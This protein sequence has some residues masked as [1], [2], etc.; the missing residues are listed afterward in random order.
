MTEE[1]LPVV[2]LWHMHQPQ[3]RDALTGEYVLPWT[4]LHAIKDYTTWR[5]TWR[6]CRRRAPSSISRRCCIE[7]LEELA[8]AH[9][10]HLVQSGA[11]L[12]DPVL[13]LLGPDDPRYR[14]SGSQLLRACLRAHRK[15]LIERFPPYLA[16]APSPSSCASARAHQLRLRCS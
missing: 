16:L 3:Y 13:A 6:R 9:R 7:Q 14:P 1:R 11:P 12:P 10:Q 15:N 2:L 4:Y 8:A 5:R